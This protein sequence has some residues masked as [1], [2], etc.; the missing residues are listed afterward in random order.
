[1]VEDN[2]IIEQDGGEWDPQRDCSTITGVLDSSC[3]GD[4]GH[5]GPTIAETLAQNGCF[6][7][8]CTKDRKGMA[9]QMRIRMK[10][11]K[12]HPT[13][14]D[15]KGEPAYIVPGIRWFDTCTSKVRTPGGKKIKV[16]PIVTIPVLPSD[17]E[18]HEKWDTD[19]NDHDADSAGYACMSRPIM[20]EDEKKDPLGGQYAVEAKLWNDDELAPRRNRGRLGY[21]GW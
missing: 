7:S 9:D 14:K 16:G 1:M 21:G 10:S 17:P 2:R 20:G 13:V 8:K 18:D 12:P 5:V 15:E 11:R 19:A 6:F 4:A 3:W